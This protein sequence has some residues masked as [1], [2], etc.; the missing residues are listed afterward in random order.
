MV[1]AEGAAAASVEVSVAFSALENGC[2]SCEDGSGTDRDVC[3]PV[4]ELV[5]AE[6]VVGG[7]GC[8]V[9]GNGVC[10]LGSVVDSAVVADDDLTCV[11]DPAVV[12]GDGV[13]CVV[14]IA[15]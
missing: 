1:W 6:S 7:E 5:V 11:L 4:I 2:A 15:R 10:V 3:S 8:A 14:V 13:D 9:L 12:V